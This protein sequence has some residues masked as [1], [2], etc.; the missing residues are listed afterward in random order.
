MVY[1]YIFVYLFTIDNSNVEFIH[2]FKNINSISFIQKCVDGRVAVLCFRNLL[3][4]GNF[5]PV[6]SFGGFFYSEIYTNDF[7]TYNLS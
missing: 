1:T 4:Y 3:S 5:F 7:Q 6:F 2:R